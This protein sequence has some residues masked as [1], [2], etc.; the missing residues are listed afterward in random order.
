MRWK[1]WSVPVFLLLLAIA[2]FAQ[3]GKIYRVGL[4]ETTSAS[5]N[6]ANLDAFHVASAIRAFAKWVYFRSVAS[7]CHFVGCSALFRRRLDCDGLVLHR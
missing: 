1:T 5:A 4:L 2:A 7:V 3:S 6:R